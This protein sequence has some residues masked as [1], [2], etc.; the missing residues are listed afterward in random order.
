MSSLTP[1]QQILSKF[2][3]AS[4]TEREK[5]TY[6]EELIR[7]YLRNEPTCADLYGDVWMLSDVP[8]EFKIGPMT[9]A[10]TCSFVTNFFVYTF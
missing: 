3:A 4:V 5:G 7:T 10:S 2:R 6:F 1:L 9:P 8:A